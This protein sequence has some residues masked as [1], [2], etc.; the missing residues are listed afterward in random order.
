MAK[1]NDISELDRLGIES[2][3]NIFNVYQEENSLYY[4]NLLQTVAF[5]QNLPPYLFTTYHIKY[6]DTWPLISYNA[7]K[8]PNF[9]WLIL[10]A[11]NIQNPM[12]PMVPG[13]QILLPIDAV[14]KQVINQIGR[15]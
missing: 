8:T 14:A 2:M 7:Y 10:L 6:G 9:W 3:E 1:Q 13:T 12:L 15:S 5:P 4:Y 11:N